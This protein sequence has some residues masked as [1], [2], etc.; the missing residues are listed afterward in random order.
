MI[1]SGID[2][3]KGGWIVITLLNGEKSEEEVCQD[4]TKVVEYVKDSDLTLIDIPIGLIDK[5]CDERQ[6][7][8]EAR[9]LLGKP[10]SSSVFPPPTRPALKGNSFEDCSYLNYKCSGR[11]LTKQAYGILPKIREVNEYFLKHPEIQNKIRETHPE[12]CFYGISGKAME[13]S[14]K[15]KEGKEER[16]EIL[17]KG[18]PL[19][20]EIYN[21]CI[22]KFKRIEV[23]K[24]DIL[25]ALVS[26]VSAKFA[27]YNPISIPEKEQRD[28]EGIRMEIVYSKL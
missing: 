24:D 18:F 5:G 15:K 7:D 17:K 3:C 23:A 21:K 26:A 13:F 16:L 11:K 4:I 27:Y 19:S 2:G 14:K 28:S 20:C 25:D 6:C 1:F 10:R 22:N 12:V 9:K 8:K